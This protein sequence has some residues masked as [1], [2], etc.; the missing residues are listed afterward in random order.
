MGTRERVEVDRVACPGLIKKFVDPQAEFY[1]VP[2]E[3]VLAAAGKLGTTS[4]NVKGLTLATTVKNAPSRRF[5]KRITE[6]MTLRSSCWARKSL[7]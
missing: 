1:F 6:R 4:Y 2:A 3:Q 5:S 7:T